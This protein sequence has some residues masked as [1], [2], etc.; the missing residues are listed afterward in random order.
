MFEKVKNLMF[1]LSFLLV[2]GNGKISSE[3]RG[4]TW[5]CE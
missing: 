2:L 4:L 3:K 1:F 5:G